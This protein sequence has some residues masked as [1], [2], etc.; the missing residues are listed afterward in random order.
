MSDYLTIPDDYKFEENF[1]KRQV[2]RS[3]YPPAFADAF[4]EAN[5]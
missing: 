2:A 1:T 5:I 4:Y 3:M